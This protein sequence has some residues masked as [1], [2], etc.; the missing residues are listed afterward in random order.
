MCISRYWQQHALP[1]SQNCSVLQKKLLLVCG[2][3]Q[4]L[5]CN[6]TVLLLICA[7]DKLKQ[8]LVTGRRLSSSPLVLDGRRC[9]RTG[10]R[11]IVRLKTTAQQHTAIDLKCQ[12]SHGLHSASIYWQLMTIL[13][14]LRQGYYNGQRSPTSADFYWTHINYHRKKS[15]WSTKKTD[16]IYSRSKQALKGILYN[17]VPIPQTK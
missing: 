15:I 9:W 12:Q 4:D 7:W 13:K 2:H 11:R 3:I 16:I 1:Y 14:Y 6:V 5:E 8:Y 10:L 17:A